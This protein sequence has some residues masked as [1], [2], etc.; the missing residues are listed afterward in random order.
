MTI[1]TNKSLEK[2]LK[3]GTKYFEVIAH[4]NKGIMLINGD[5]GKYHYYDSWEE[6]EI[7]TT[8]DFDVSDTSKLYEF[9][10]N[11]FSAAFIYPIEKKDEGRYSGIFS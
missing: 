9:L 6:S 1:H 2:A 10:R 5:K 8:E 11:E 7:D 4:V 3:S